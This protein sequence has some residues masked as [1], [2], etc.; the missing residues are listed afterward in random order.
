MPRSIVLGNGNMLVGMDHHGLVRDLYYDQVGL[1]NHTNGQPQR[2]GVFVDGQ[3]SWI[4]SRGW[5][6]RSEYLPETMISNIVA[7]NLHLNIRINFE[8]FVYNETDIFIR[9]VSLENTSDR[10]R[11]IRVYFHNDL[12]ISGHSYGV[13]AFYYP[14]RHSI[15][16]YRGP[17]VFLFGGYLDKNPMSDF[18]VGM[19]RYAGLQGTWKDAEDG[20]LSSNSIEHGQVDS[21]LE[22]T[23]TLRGKQKC[24][25]YY[26]MTAGK[27]LE[28][29]IALNDDIQ[30]RSPQHLYQTTRDYWRAWVNKQNYSF[31][32]L[33]DQQVELFK[34]SLLVMR[35]HSDNRGAIIA[36]SDSEMLQHGKDTYGYMWPRDG[37]Y[38]AMAFA[39]A[40]YWDMARK[41]FEFTTDLIT[42][43]GFLMHK[44]LPDGSLGSSWHAWVEGDHDI[45]PIQEDETA[46]MLFALWVY[47]DR[48]RDIEFIEAIY[49]YFIKSAANFLIKY[50][51]AS[52]DLP[53]HSYDL[54][55]E[56][57]AVSTYTASSVVGGLE[58]AA[59][60]ADLLGKGR[61]K[62][63]FKKAA[64]EIRA[65]IKK[66]LV[67]KRQVSTY[68]S[69]SFDRKG[70]MT[71]DKR[72]DASS[73]YGLLLFDVFHLEDPFTL[74]CADACEASLWKRSPIG[75]MARYEGDAY[76]KVDDEPNPW[77]I[78]TLWH[79]AYK[80]RSA[81][82]NEDLQEVR[83][84]FQWVVDRALPSGILPEQVHPKTGAPLSATPLVWSHSEYVRAVIEYMEKLEE[85]DVIN[86]EHPLD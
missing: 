4:G 27:T 20:K 44:Y 25:G 51:H 73:F 10:E 76:Y 58:A 77:I 79:T 39:K 81:K 48:S 46:I 45:L 78:T 68:K 62:A 63:R 21:T 34:R 6:V 64:K 19:T 9:K 1:E 15:V 14:K 7:E 85:L 41:F 57:R 38:I 69:V 22:F 72:I 32:G 83:N 50:R 36:S 61:D 29:A 17:K 84:I 65:A 75:G 80:I 60:F 13:T 2:I 26:W 66:Y 11:N 52:T 18:S 33:N 53:L 42:E 59:K 16:H 30:K 55:E 5:K 67:D 3:I 35:A 74:V 49:N 71:A 23:C 12:T 86:M 28:D 54:W 31:Y 47:Y 24:E 43:E 37:A 8:D 40:G 82:T 70:K 56:H